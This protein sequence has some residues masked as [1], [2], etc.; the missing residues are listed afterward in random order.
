MP[1]ALVT[2]YR[3]L[4]EAGRWDDFRWLA[5]SQGLTP[6]RIVE[7]WERLLARSRRASSLHDPDA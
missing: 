1:K 6:E 4:V 5:R 2:I 7:L 3:E